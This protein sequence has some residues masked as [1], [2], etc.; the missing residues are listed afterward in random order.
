MHIIPNYGYATCTIPVCPPE[1][2]GCKLQNSHDLI[3]KVYSKSQQSLKISNRRQKLCH[4]P[5]PLTLSGNSRLR[6]PLQRSSDCSPMYQNLRPAFRM[7]KALRILEAMP[8]D[9]RWR[10]LLLV[11]RHFSR[12]YM[13]VATTLILHSRVLPGV[14]LREMVM[15][16]SMVHGG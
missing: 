3:K 7:L 6:H 2:S 13:P 5:F 9:G 10:K 12:Q 16:W 15:H 1:W 8:S 14:Q 11:T 4:L